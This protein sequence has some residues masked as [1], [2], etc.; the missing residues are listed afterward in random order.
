M[1]DKLSVLS[2]ATKETE[3]GRIHKAEPG[4]YGRK[5]D[6]DEEGDEKDGEKDAKKPQEKR[7][8]GRQQKQVLM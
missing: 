1:L 3:K 5:Y 2:E 8:R 6:T 7:G 4:G